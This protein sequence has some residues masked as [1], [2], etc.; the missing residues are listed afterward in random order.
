MTKE[1][2]EADDRYRNATQEVSKPIFGSDDMP[3]WWWRVPK[4]LVGEL[5]RDLEN[6]R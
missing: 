3:W 4:R 6:L 2:A 1:I 5:G